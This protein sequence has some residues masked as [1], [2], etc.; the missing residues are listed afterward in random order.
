MWRQMVFVAMVG[1][2]G[3]VACGPADG[4]PTG[5]AGCPV[6]DGAAVVIDGSHVI[7]DRR[8]SS[9]TCRY[10]CVD[11]WW[12]CP[13]AAMCGARHDDDANCGACGRR[14]ADGTRCALNRAG[15]PECLTP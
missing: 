7:V 14:C 6:S 2:L 12:N 9:G 8:P 3:G 13:D 4:D 10:V 15:A 1:L 11:G 5:D